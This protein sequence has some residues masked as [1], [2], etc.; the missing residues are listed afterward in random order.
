MD[1]T[2]VYKMNSFISI[3]MIFGALGWTEVIIE[4]GFESS[5]IVML[6]VA[7]VVG[8]LTLIANRWNRWHR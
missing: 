4:C 2:E 3:W 5:D 1:I 6:P 7:M 8:P